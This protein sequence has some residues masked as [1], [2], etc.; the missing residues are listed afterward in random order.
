MN[1]TSWFIIIGA[2]LFIVFI[3][4]STIAYNISTI[5]I[6]SQLSSI[7]MNTTYGGIKPINITVFGMTVYE[8]SGLGFATI[9]TSLETIADFPLWFNTIFI[10]LPF[11]IFSILGIL[12]LVNS[13][14][15]GSS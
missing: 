3:A 4:I 15:G 1:K 14:S 2:Y 10:I 5:K 12:I 6:Q 11:I 8:S 9:V 7:S 13:L